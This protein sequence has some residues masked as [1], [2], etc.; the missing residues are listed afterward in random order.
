MLLY[1]LLFSPV[2]FRHIA[3][4]ASFFLGTA[5]YT[6]SFHHHVSPL[7]IVP[8]FFSHTSSLAFKTPF[9][10]CPH[11]SGAP[12]ST[13]LVIFSSNH[14]LIFISFN[15]A[16]FLLSAH[17]FL[18]TFLIF[19]LSISAITKAC[20]NSPRIAFTF[21]INHWCSFV[22]NTTSISVSFWPILN[23]TFLFS[24]L[25]CHAFDM[26]NSFSRQNS[27]NILPCK[28]LW[29][30][31]YPPCTPLNNQYAYQHVHWSH[32]ST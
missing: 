15:K 26:H 28:F 32:P 29:P 18:T 14:F 13:D 8:L 3:L 7:L 9:L 19:L 4:S 6:S 5:F 25:L 11:K 12:T 16:I 30:T 2:L 10:K 22:I 31:P 1:L 17:V 24:S 21:W 23:V 20:W 27:N